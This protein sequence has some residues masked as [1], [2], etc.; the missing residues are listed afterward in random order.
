VP[1]RSV[2]PRVT[3]WIRRRQGR[4][5]VIVTLVAVSLV[6]TVR[7]LGIRPVE[8]DEPVAF[9]AVLSPEPDPGRG[10]A[11]GLLVRAD[12]CDAAVDVHLVAAP[13]VE[14]W[15]DWRRTGETAAPTMTFVLPDAPRRV[16]FRLG[17][18][19]SDIILPQDVADNRGRVLKATRIGQPRPDG[20]HRTV[21]LFRVTVPD[22]QRSL[23]PVVA[24]YSAPWL[25]PRALGS[26]WLHLPALTG[27]F[28]VL[29]AQRVDPRAT[30]GSRDVRVFSRRSGFEAPY[31]SSLEPVRGST[32]VMGTRADV[33][34]DGSLP[35][36]DSTTN[37][38]ATWTCSGSPVRDV[39]LI[40]DP[41]TKDPP[42]ILLAR[43]RPSAGALSADAI[44]R[45]SA[46]DCSAVAIVEEAS[47]AARRDFLLVVLGA[48]MGLVTSMMLELVTARPQYREGGRDS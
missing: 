45:G 26:C 19:A 17:E 35:S 39:A 37:G 4:I 22:W 3:R 30:L 46:R 31:D 10:V 8:R 2:A 42:D 18:S 5:T 1:A 14:Y 43:Q 6:A 25:D 29:S 15:Q 27:D 7:W 38:S 16:E 36:P 9:A 28:S 11:L 47:A 20:P 41:E 32:V 34:S 33:R 48:F 23:A 21:S 24:T 12:N 44:G 40:G 13:T